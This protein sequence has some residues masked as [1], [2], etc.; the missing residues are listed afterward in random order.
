[1]AYLKMGVSGRAGKEKDRAAL[2]CGEAGGGH[3]YCGKI[4]L[5]IRMTD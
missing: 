2:H 5:L 1:M 4:V 3:S